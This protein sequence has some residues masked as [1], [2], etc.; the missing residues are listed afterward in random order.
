MAQSLAYL[1][2][3]SGSAGGGTPS[4]SSRFSLPTSPPTSSTPSSASFYSHSTNPSTSTVSTPLPKRDGSRIVSA[5]PSSLQQTL[6]ASSSH[7]APGSIL[8]RPLNRTKGAEV[9]LGAFAFLFA[10]IVSY[11]QSRVDSVTDLEKR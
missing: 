2:G 1:G 10:E 5:G 9:S 11:S 3:G 4:S 8:D 6:F 7:Q